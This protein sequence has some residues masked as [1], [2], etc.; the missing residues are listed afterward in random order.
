MDRHTLFRS[1]W[2]DQYLAG[3][4]QIFDSGM[5]TYSAKAPSES[6]PMIFTCWH[7]GFAGAALLRWPR[8]RDRGYVLYVPRVCVFGLAVL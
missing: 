6:T 7:V 3:F 4:A 8:I 5:T 1:V 2:I